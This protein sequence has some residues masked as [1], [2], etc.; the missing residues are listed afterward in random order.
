[1]RLREIEERTDGNN[2]GGINLSV[3]HVIVALDMIEID[4]VCDSW[5]LI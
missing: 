2:A 5:L 1:M 4:R 3:R